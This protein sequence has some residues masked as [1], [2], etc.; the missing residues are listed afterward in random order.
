MIVETE[1][2]REINPTNSIHSDASWADVNAHSWIRCVFPLHVTT[3]A[4]IAFLQLKGFLQSVH[5][6]FTLGFCFRQTGLLDPT[7]FSFQ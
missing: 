4:V 2:H 1:L 5:Q 6:L 3:V 7:Q